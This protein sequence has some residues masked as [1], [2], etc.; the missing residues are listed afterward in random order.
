MERPLEGKVA[1][2]TGASS[3]IGAAIARALVDAGARVH[4]TARRGDMIKD[5][6]GDEHASAG[7]VVV[8]PLDLTDVEA[9]ET[10]VREIIDVD[11]IDILVCAA[12]TNITD[13]RFSQLT[14][15]S[16]ETVR[17]VNL[18]SIFHLLRV[19]MPQFRTNGGDIVLIASVAAAWPD[20]TGAAYQASKAGL[21]GLGRAVSRD[22]HVHGVR[23]TSILPGIVDTPILD[24]R[25]SPP[26]HAVRDWCVK[27]EDVAAATLAAVTLPPRAH[28]PEMTVIATRLQSMGNTQ[29]ATPS[30]PEALSGPSVGR[31]E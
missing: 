13:R 21:V 6:L 30:L 26:P 23:V 18:D 29:A 4:A 17:S 24:L 9:L 20:H 27:P 14:R 3:G 28:I 1:L 31:T 8:H 10:T 25:P 15:A 11:P 19:T 22:E 16:W 7:R 2:V 5:E 12:G